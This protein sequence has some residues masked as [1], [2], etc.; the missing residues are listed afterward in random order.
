M[1]GMQHKIVQEMV[2]SGLVS[3]LTLSRIELPSVYTFTCLLIL[4]VMELNKGRGP[5][6]NTISLL[7]QYCLHSL[8]SPRPL[9]M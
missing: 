5:V 3:H 8:V 7:L 9:L 4:I 6:F 2:L 1:V